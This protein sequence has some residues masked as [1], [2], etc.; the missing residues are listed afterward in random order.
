MA[1]INAQQVK[2]L[3]DR[4]GA[5]MMDCKQ[6]LADSNGNIDQAIEWLRKKGLKNVAKRSD[7]ET[8]EGQIYSYI[9][10]NSKVGVM[11][12]LNCETDFVGR[13][14]EFTDLAKSIAMHVA[15]ARPR[16]LQREDI[17][18]EVIDKEAEIARSQLTPQQEKVA[19]KIISGKI[20]KFYEEVVLL[21]Q[22]DAR[23]S[24]GKKKISDLIS[25][26][27]SKVGEKIVLKRFARFELGERA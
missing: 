13:G 26:L 23:D 20:E 21:E 3:R 1:E 9:H 17:P 7:R 8:S 24:A 4:T 14:A 22:L 15:W 6:A 11:L 18:A 10:P 12:E 27:S 16:Y 19:D 5:G 25:D 2:D